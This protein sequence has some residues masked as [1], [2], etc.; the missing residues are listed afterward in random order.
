M[1]PRAQ[2]ELSLILRLSEGSLCGF[3]IDGQT[4]ARSLETEEYAQRNGHEVVL[5]L[6]EDAADLLHDSDHD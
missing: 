1:A 5:I 2:D 4:C 6:A 3:Y